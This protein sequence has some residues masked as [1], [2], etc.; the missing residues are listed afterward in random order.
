VHSADQ[1]VD[2][3]PRE[4]RV[5]LKQSLDVAQWNHETAARLEGHDR[6][7]ARAS[8]E[9]QLAEIVALADRAENNLPAVLLAH[10]HLGASGEQNVQGVGLVTFVDDH[11]ILGK[12]ARG[13]ARRELAQCPFVETG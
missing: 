3:V 7:G 5:A 10:E 13:A 8:A 4:Q 6:S 1:H 9:N 2:Q 12:R 11:R